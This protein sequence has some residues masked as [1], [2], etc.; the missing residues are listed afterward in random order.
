MDVE[1]LTKYSPYKKRPLTSKPID[2]NLI[3]RPKTAKYIQADFNLSNK[4]K[5]LELIKK[6][7]PRS[8]KLEK[9]R[10]YEEN[11]ALKQNSNNLTDELLRI[12][13]KYLKL[14]REFRK[15]DEDG[16]I[17]YSGSGSLVSNLKHLIKSLKTEVSKKDFELEKLKKNK[18]YTKITEYEVQISV[19]NDECTRLKYKLEEIMAKNASLSQN[20]GPKKEDENFL[21]TVKEEKEALNSKI[22]ELVQENMMLKN[23]ILKF[24]DEKMEL[25]EKNKEI[26]KQKSEIMKLKKRNS[27]VTKLETVLEQNKELEKTLKKLEEE[28]DLKN[29][30]LAKQEKYK[31]K[32]LKE[33]KKKYKA[34]IA[35]LQ[36]DVQ[37]KDKEWEKTI[38]G[39]QKQLED[40]EENY[41][42]T[43][44][45]IQS[46]AKMKK[47]DS[48]IIGKK[49]NLEDKKGKSDDKSKKNQFIE[50]LERELEMKN[51][52]YEELINRHGQESEDL[53]NKLK[54][55]ECQVLELN[56]LADHKSREIQEFGIILQQKTKELQDLNKENNE[57]KEEIQKLN[58]KLEE[59]LTEIEKLNLK[60]QINEDKLQEFKSSK[61]DSPP[62]LFKILNEVLQREGKGILELPDSLGSEDPITTDDLYQKLKA[63]HEKLKKTMIYEVSGLLKINS[64]LLSLKRLSDFLTLFSYDSKDFYSSDEDTLSIDKL[65]PSNPENQPKKTEKNEPVAPRNILTNTES[66]KKIIYSEA[67]EFPELKIKKSN[68]IKQQEPLA[69]E[70]TMQ[71]VHKDALNQSFSSNSEKGQSGNLNGSFDDLGKNHLNKSFKGSE[72][73]FS[74]RFNKSSR[75]NS[76]YSSDENSEK[77]PSSSLSSKKARSGYSDTK[78][79]VEKIVKPNTVQEKQLPFSDSPKVSN[80]RKTSTLKSTSIS[81]IAEQ[82]FRHFTFRLQLSNISKS[83]SIHNLFPLHSE[84]DQITGADLEHRLQ[85]N[86]FSFSYSESNCLASCIFTQP[87]LTLKALQEKFLQITEDWQILTTEKKNVIEQQLKKLFSKNFAKILENCRK[88]EKNNSH[89]VSVNDFQQVLNKLG[90]VIDPESFNYFLLICYSHEKKLDDVPYLA[91]MQR[92]TDIAE[93]SKEQGQ[94]ETQEIARHYLAVIA[95][96]LIQNR[97]RARDLFETN[98][99]GMIM[100]KEFLIGLDKVGLGGM[101]VE[102]KVALLDALHYEQADEHCVSLLEFEGILEYYGVGNYEEEARDVPLLKSNKISE[103]DSVDFGSVNQSLNNSIRED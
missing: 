41:K 32:E 77:G 50:S 36:E 10:L 3:H 60:S 27:E 5:D 6:L 63:K 20:I 51:K 21:K 39:L 28:L 42:K 87:S 80:F 8:I 64:N 13:T 69:I 71:K 30:E 9:E 61:H 49:M 103:L 48:E 29:K 14:E 65:I 12:K 25:L 54:N 95:K 44:E 24:E 102:Y 26:E 17:I 86:P 18:N 55:S 59:K 33:M 35:R 43:V 75:S 52:E 76:D 23:K 72:K 15:L 53:K 22:K 74:G 34:S 101:E 40:R 31:I 83:D 88:V 82:L 100:P 92:L 78:E 57:I 45:K 90:I 4:Q 2:K 68:S 19:F 89:S 96:V 99:K 70:E 97:K 46:E 56:A 73:A 47:S 91:I 93:D 38:E 1:E 98:G 94:T 79:K 85:S 16:Q 81:S 62:R 11:L 58:S 84:T 7:K 67:E 37:S 66:N